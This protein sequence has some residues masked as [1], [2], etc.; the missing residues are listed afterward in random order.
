MF[1][2]HWKDGISWILVVFHWLQWDSHRVGKPGGFPLGFFCKGNAPH[3][4]VIATPNVN[5]VL[6]NNYSQTTIECPAQYA[7]YNFC[8]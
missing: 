1:N 2:V 6:C 8:Q 4:F 7:P 5:A 3:V